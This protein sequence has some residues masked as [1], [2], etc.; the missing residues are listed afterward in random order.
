MSLEGRSKGVDT[1]GVKVVDE[2]GV[3]WVR[4]HAFLSLMYMSL[5]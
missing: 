2:V 5:L 3:S 4:S 1:G